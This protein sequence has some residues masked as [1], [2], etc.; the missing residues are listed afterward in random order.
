MVDV[1][2]G[3]FHVVIKIHLITGL[4]NFR[5]EDK[6]DETRETIGHQSVHFGCVYR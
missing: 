5:R 6:N 3:L 1:Q 4:I 2:V